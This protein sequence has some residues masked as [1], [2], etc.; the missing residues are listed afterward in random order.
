MIV[1]VACI[2]L[3]S[4]SPTFIYVSLVSVIQHDKNDF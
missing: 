1:H 4:S 2:V 3:Y